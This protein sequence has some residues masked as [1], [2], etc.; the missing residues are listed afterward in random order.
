MASAASALPALTEE[1]GGLA[2]G[3]MG[4][5]VVQGRTGG[6]RAIRI[7]ETPSLICATLLRAAATAW[8]TSSL[9][10]VPPTPRDRAGAPTFSPRGSVPIELSDVETGACGGLGG[11][12]CGRIT[13]GGTTRNCAN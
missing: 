8:S 2:G 6:A 11:C 10:R 12:G 7:A 4:E 5:L 13:P 1:E 9:D 3:L